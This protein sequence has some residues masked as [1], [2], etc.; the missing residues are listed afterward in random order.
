MLALSIA[1]LWRRRRRRQL[2]DLLEAFVVLMCI[3]TGFLVWLAVH[4][5]VIRFTP[6]EVT[7]SAPAWLG[8]E[9]YTKLVYS[10][11]DW[12]GKR[13]RIIWEHD[14]RRTNIVTRM[15]GSKPVWQPKT[16]EECLVQLRGGAETQ[17]DL[18]W[19][20]NGACDEILNAAQA[21]GVTV[22]PVERI[23]Q[24]KPTG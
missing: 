12:V 19:G 11:I 17:M 21:A 24:P 6:T 20:V 16:I 13:E 1:V 4:T 10:Q 8:G 5:S 9:T 15:L 2:F 3:V 14:P 18:R 23:I 22:K 7:V